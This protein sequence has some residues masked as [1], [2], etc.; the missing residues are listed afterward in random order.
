M[1]DSYVLNL[2]IQGIFTSKEILLVFIGL[3]KDVLGFSVQSY[4]EPEE[5]FGLPNIFWID[6]CF[7]QI[8]EVF[9]NVFP[10]FSLV[11]YVSLIAAFIHFKVLSTS[12]L[13]YFAI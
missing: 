10:P 3:A 13:L 8:P 11:C 6:V 9:L 1:L 5:T 12:F 2:S 4:E 7:P